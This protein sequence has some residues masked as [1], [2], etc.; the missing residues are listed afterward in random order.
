MNIVWPPSRI[1][2]LDRQ[3]KFSTRP[4]SRNGKRTEVD[5]YIAVRADLPPLQVGSGKLP[6]AKNGSR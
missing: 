2:C 1:L 5:T 3:L 6:N 4:S